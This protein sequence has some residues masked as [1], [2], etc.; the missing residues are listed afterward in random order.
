MFLSLALA[1][2]D[3]STRVSQDSPFQGKLGK[4]QQDAAAPS[5]IHCH[6]FQNKNNTCLSP[7]LD[8]HPTLSRCSPNEGRYVLGAQDGAA[9]I[10]ALIGRSMASP[11][12]CTH[13]ACSG[14]REI[15][16]GPNDQKLPEGHESPGLPSQWPSGAQAPRLLWPA[17]EERTFFCVIFESAE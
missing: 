7:S 16:P 9:L 11:C 17:G 1:E 5:A 2:A 14:C 10:L 8:D 4:G 6:K 13:A 3:L 12:A 15:L